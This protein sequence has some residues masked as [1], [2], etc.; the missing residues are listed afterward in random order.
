[1]AAVMMAMTGMP[2]VM[3]RM[4][5]FAHGKSLAVIAAAPVVMPVVTAALMTAM[6]V[7]EPAAMRS[8]VAITS[9]GKLPT[10]ISAAPLTVPLRTIAATVRAVPGEFPTAGTTTFDHAG[11][12]AVMPRASFSTAGSHG[13]RTM[14]SRSRMKGDETVMAMRSPVSDGCK[15]ARSL[16]AGPSPGRH[17]AARPVPLARG[18]CRTAAMISSA[19]LTPFPAGG[20]SFTTIAPAAITR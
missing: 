4:T 14:E 9:F 20:G 1:M 18:K 19:P 2:V 5:V 10:V 7:R 15:A 11:M 16:R 13:F 8:A 12:T 17:H 6:M 3:S